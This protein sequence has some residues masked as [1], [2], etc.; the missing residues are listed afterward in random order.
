MLDRAME[1]R[2]SG[3][4]G[5]RASRLLLRV[6]IAGTL[7]AGGYYLFWRYTASVNW[8]VWPL[9][10][11]LL[12]AETYTYLDAWLFGLTLWRLKRRPPPGPP[13]PDASVDVF[14]TCYNEP[15]D[16]VRR[17]VRAAV[18]LRYPHHTYVLDD[19]AS[20]AMRRMAEEEGAGYVVRSEDWHGRDRHAKAGNI[21]NALLQTSGEFI[22]FLDADQ[23][24]YPHALDH[25]L[26][27]FADSQMALVQSPQVFYNVPKDDPFNSHAPLFYGPIQQGKD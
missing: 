19:G 15:V 11:A 8:T 2:T 3:I 22:L 16:L 17:T 4:W 9:A 12:L 10:L 25:L 23:I 6:L 14:I 20:P 5:E 26:G 1:R 18:Q 27:Y 7:A 24:P 13:P 21:S